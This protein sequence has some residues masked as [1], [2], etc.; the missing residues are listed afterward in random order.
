MKKPIVTNEKLKMLVDEL[1]SK[2]DDAIGDG[3]IADAIRYELKT[4][5]PVKGRFHSKKGRDYIARLQN[6]LG[7]KKSPNLESDKKIAREII[8]DLRDAL[9]GED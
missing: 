3:S 6:W 7:N 2:A 8:Q 9:K 5:N 4:G 1:W